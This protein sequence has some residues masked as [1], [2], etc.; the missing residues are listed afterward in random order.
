MTP[1]THGGNVPI[2][3]RIDRLARLVL[4]VLLLVTLGLISHV[5]IQGAVEDAF[6]KTGAPRILVAKPELREEMIAKRL[7]RRAKAI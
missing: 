5:R 6:A 3:D 4:V 7:E 2:E 1:F